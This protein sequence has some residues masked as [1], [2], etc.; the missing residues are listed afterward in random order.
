MTQQRDVLVIGAGVI[1]VCSAYYLQKAGRRVTIV[2]RDEVCSGSSYGNAGW[3]VP[4]HSVPLAAPGAV[5]KGLRW[6]FNPESPFYIKPRLDLDLLKWLLRFRAAANERAVRRSLPVLCGLSNA[7]LALYQKLVVDEALDC[8]YEQ[9]GLMG[10]YKTDRGYEVGIEEAR[11][12]EEFGI[13]TRVLSS[14]E[15]VEMAPA[16][17]SDLAGGIFFDDD[18]HLKP[19]DFVNGLASRFQEQGGEIL[20]G[21]KVR[22]FE[23]AGRRIESVETSRGGFHPDKVVLAAG[24]W[25]P[26]VARDLKLKLPVQPAKGYS[27]TFDALDGVIPFPIML[28]EARM[29]VTPLGPRM[30]LAGTLELSG[31]NL[32]IK[33]RRV[34]ALRRGPARYF[35]SVLERTNEQVWCGM[36]PLSPDGLPIIGVPGGVSNLIVATGHSMTGVTQGPATGKLVSEI[37]TGEATIIDPTPVSPRRFG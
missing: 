36:R 27:I 7:S 16:V 11:V 33:D 6:M 14:S 35:N 22:G 26:G 3:I 20:T 34:D 37:A 17:R 5:L 31:I 18:A 2:E 21:T 25:S 19:D 13:P 15:V 4:S 9:T 29:G 8:H 12:L 24:A 32:D 1:G 28:A 30:R 23:L 10:L